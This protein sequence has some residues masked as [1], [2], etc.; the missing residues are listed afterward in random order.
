LSRS[1]TWWA[2]VFPV[3]VLE[4]TGIEAFTRSKRLVVP[5]SGVVLAVQRLVASP[6]TGA[7]VTAV[8]AGSLATPFIALCLVI[9]Y[10]DLRSRFA[11]PVSVG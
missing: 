10:A 2:L 5:M 9:P 6:E 11:P 1:L 8:V 3:V 7:V 4:R